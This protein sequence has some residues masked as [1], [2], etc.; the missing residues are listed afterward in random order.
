MPEQYSIVCIY[1]M[2]LQFWHSWHKSEKNL[3]ER[4]YVLHV[5][6]NTVYKSQDRTCVCS[7]MSGCRCVTKC[8]SKRNGQRR[9]SLSCL[10]I[11]KR[12]TIPNHYATFTKWRL[13]N[14]FM[15]LILFL[16]YLFNLKT[17]KCLIH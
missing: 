14:Y 4:I 15:L 13:K 17:A 12:G 1:H 7:I 8:P 9:R 10:N 6:G 3:S 5:H 16:M 2:T 11:F